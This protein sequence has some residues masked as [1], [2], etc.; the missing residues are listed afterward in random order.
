[1]MSTQPNALA[2]LLRAIEQAQLEIARYLDPGVNQSAE[3]TVEAVM[4]I[5]DHRDLQATMQAMGWTPTPL[6]PP[7]SLTVID[8]DKEQ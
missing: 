6:I 7:L 5:L 1:M 4:A 3:A 2:V 8:G